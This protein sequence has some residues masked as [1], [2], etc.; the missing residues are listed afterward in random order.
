MLFREWSCRDSGCVIEAYNINFTR[1]NPGSLLTN[2]QFNAAYLFH[3]KMQKCIQN[4]NRMNP[5]SERH[6]SLAVRDKC[7]WCLSHAY[8]GKR[9]RHLQNEKVIIKVAGKK[10]GRESGWS[11]SDLHF[12]GTLEEGTEI[13]LFLHKKWN[14]SMFYF[15]FLNATNIMELY[16]WMGINKTN[17]T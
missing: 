3:S 4:C 8:T 9:S 10:W 2:F 11:Y 17:Q 5:T 6:T 15:F 14:C 7:N 13:N 16:Q 1:L 12:T